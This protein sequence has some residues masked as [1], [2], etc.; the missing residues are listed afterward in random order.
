MIMFKEDVSGAFNQLN[1]SSRSAKYLGVMIDDDVLF[2]MITGGFGHCVTP[3]IWSVVG[4]AINRRAQLFVQCPI[5]I[6]VDD[7]VGAGMV[8]HALEAQKIVQRSTEEVLGEGSTA[9]DKSSNG[10]REV[11]FGFLVDFVT[12]TL[13][14]K[15][16]AIDKIFFVFFNVDTSVPQ[17]LE[18]WQCLASIA[19]FY[20]QGVRG[21]S[22]F[23]APLHYMTRKCTGHCHKSKASASAQFAI[24]MWRVMAILLLV[25]D[26]VSVSV[27]LDSFL[28][29]PSSPFSKSFPMLV[30][31]V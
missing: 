17:S 25:V 5:D 19:Q 26:R 12:A 28:L 20:S 14:P 24:E 16:L 4:E 3:M 21:M 7:T 29:S 2:I 23:V 6:F 10:P 30:H 18:V 31:G 22:A 13:S 8:S 1:W 27:P 11:I 15:D 9:P